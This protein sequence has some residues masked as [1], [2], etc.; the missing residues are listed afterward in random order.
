MPDGTGGY[1]FVT[2]D[3][4]DEDAVAE[5]FAAAPGRITGVVHSA[6]VASG[7]PVHLPTAPSGTASS[8]ST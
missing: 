7:G 3:V 2:A 5:V 1:T 4:T 6:G 8:P